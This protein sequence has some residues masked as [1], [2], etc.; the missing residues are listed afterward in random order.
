MLLQQIVSIHAADAQQLAHA[1]ATELA[2]LP[3]QAQQRDL[4][5]ERAR[6]EPRW[7]TMEDGCEGRGV[8]RHFPQVVRIGCN[9]WTDEALV[10]RLGR[11][12]QQQQF[13]I[14][15][16]RQRRQLAGNQAQAVPFECQFAIERLR[17]LI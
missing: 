7:R 16:Q 6:P 14:A 11:A 12:A 1:L 15:R 3:A 13:A 4:I 9:V 5:R 17:H 8:A 10:A 2:D